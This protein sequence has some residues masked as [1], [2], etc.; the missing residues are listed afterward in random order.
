VRKEKAK[1]LGRCGEERSEVDGKEV[2]GARRGDRAPGKRVT[3]GTDCGCSGP[4]G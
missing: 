2:G 3:L 1:A 4:A